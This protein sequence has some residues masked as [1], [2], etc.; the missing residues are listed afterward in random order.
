MSKEQEERDLAEN[1]R[2]LLLSPEEREAEIAAWIPRVQELIE[3][4]GKIREPRMRFA[5][6]SSYRKKLEELMD[7]VERDD[8]SPFTA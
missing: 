7:A 4:F 3:D 8:K 1:C 6:Q 5:L 2:W